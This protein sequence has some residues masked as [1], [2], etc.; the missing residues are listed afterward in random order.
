MSLK[1]FL[2]VFLLIFFSGLTIFFKEF[3]LDLFHSKSP[4]N[5][6][7][8]LE[9]EQAPDFY[10]DDVNSTIATQVD[11]SSE[12]H[13][14]NCFNIYRCV[15]HSGKQKKFHVHIPAPKRFI[16]KLGELQSYQEVNPMTYE[17]VEILEAIAESE[18]YTSNPESACIFIPALDLLNEFELKDPSQASKAL[19]FSSPHWKQLNGGEN[20]LL[21]SFYPGSLTKRLKQQQTFK[22]SLSFLSCHILCL[23]KSV[24]NP[25]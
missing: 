19:E 2:V 20:H 4:D 11:R 13:F 15:D 12:C 3:L 7:I 9:L 23:F 25:A 8:L 17:F 1:T 21:F 6:D 22:T 5:V 24:I 10:L 14:Y 16:S 18:Y